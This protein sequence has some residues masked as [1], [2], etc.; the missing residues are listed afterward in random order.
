MLWRVLTAR[1]DCCN[2]VFAHPEQ[3]PEYLAELGE[4]L[5]L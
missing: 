3:L 1:L 2:D 5:D 4:T